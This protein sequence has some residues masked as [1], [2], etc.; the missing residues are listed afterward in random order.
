MTDDGAPAAADDPFARVYDYFKHLTTVSLIAIG[1]VLG[2]LSGDGP[3]LKP[4]AI[5][6]VVGTLGFAG[7]LAMMMMASLSALGFKTPEEVA[8]IRRVVLAIQ[9][10]ATFL[11]MFGL[12]IFLGAFVG[13][14]N[15]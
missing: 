1:G 13:T 8:R 5:V 12:G 11:L 7:F 4:I 6:I 2:L 15:R 9:G 3:V 14:I 10:A